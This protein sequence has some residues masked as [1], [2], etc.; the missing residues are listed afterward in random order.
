MSRPGRAME[1]PRRRR[2][3]FLTWFFAV[4]GIVGVGAAAVAGGT[5]PVGGAPSPGGPSPASPGA[6]G[7]QS[8]GGDRLASERR[9]AHA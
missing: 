6:G 8:S 1:E 2:N 5:L 4:I 3:G 7:Q 9:H